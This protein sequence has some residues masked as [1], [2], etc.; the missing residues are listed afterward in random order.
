MVVGIE[1]QRLLEVLHHIDVIALTILRGVLHD[2]D[3]PN[4]LADLYN[5][6][7]PNF[8]LDLEVSAGFA[9]RVGAR[10]PK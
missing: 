7:P 1:F 8:R 5:N 2:A 3:H 10:A 6:I 9:I 4:R